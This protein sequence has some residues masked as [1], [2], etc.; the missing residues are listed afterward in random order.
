M[1]NKNKNKNIP[2]CAYT[3]QVQ[4]I[5]ILVADWGSEFAGFARILR[6]D[7]NAQDWVMISPYSRDHRAWSSKQKKRDHRKRAGHI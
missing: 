7:I 4:S 5:D 2:G 1:N 6:G 3:P